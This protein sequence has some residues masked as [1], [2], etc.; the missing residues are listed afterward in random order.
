MVV[1]IQGNSGGR[2]GDGQARTVTWL[3]SSEM[4]PPRRSYKQ[5]GLPFSISFR[6]CIAN[7][8]NHEYAILKESAVQLTTPEVP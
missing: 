8:A 4:V 1:V 7:P 6:F 3:A 2:V 5:P